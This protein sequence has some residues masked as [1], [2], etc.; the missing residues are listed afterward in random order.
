MDS[1][2]R[3]ARLKLFLIKLQFGLTIGGNKV[4]MNIVNLRHDTGTAFLAGIDAEAGIFRTAKNG[5]IYRLN[6]ETG[7]TRGLG[8]EIDGANAVGTPGNPA[9]IGANPELK[10]FTK[11]NLA[12]HWKGGERDHSKE[13][14]G[15]TKEQYARRALELARSPVSDHVLGYKAANGDIVRFDESTNDFVKAAKNGIKTMFKPD[16]GARY[17]ERQMLKDGGTTD[18]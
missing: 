12:K 17:F 13:Y 3:L 11:K 16:K 8:P 2:S 10:G 1:L 4:R 15:F 5:K 6:T 7:E 18:G 14:P 9:P